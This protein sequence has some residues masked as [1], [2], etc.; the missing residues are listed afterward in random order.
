MYDICVAQLN[1]KLNSLWEGRLSIY[2]QHER[3]LMAYN[4]MPREISFVLKNRYESH[5]LCMFLN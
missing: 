4:V 1:N 5:I 2:R 3:A